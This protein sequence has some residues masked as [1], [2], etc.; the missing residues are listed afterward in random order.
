MSKN[1]ARKPLT[2]PQ[3]TFRDQVLKLLKSDGYR[4]ETK[5]G[6]SRLLDVPQNERSQLRQDLRELADQGEIE[7]RRGGRYVLAYSQQNHPSSGQSDATGVLRV[8][9]KGSGF[10]VLEKSATV[11]K[12]IRLPEKVSIQV[13]PE[14]MANALPGDRVALALTARSMPRSWSSDPRGEHRV[15]DLKSSDDLAV[16]GRVI[17]VLDRAEHRVIGSLIVEKGGALALKPDS[18]T[19]PPRLEL[20]SKETLRNP[21]NGERVL[22]EITEWSD[23]QLPPQAGLLERVGMPGDDGLAMREIVLA[24]A[25][26]E[27]FPEAVLDEARAIPIRIPEDE[28]ARR[29]DWRDRLVFTIDPGDARDF[30]D[31]ISI[32]CMENEGWELAVHIADV[33]T[34]VKPGSAMD[35]EARGRG[36]STYLPHR[37]IPMLPEELSNGICSL[38]PHEDRLTR[39]VVMQFDRQGKRGKTR[40]VSAVIHSKARLTYEE[41]MEY[42]DGKPAAEGDP[43]PEK[44]REA[45]KLASLLRKKRFQHG[46][47]DMDFPEVRVKLDARGRPVDLVVSENDASHQLIEECMLATNE[48]VARELRQRGKPCVY[49]VHEDPAEER[50]LDFRELARAAGFRVGDLS[51]RAEA[52]KLLDAAKGHPAEQAIKIGFLKSLKRADYRTESDGHYGLAKRDYTHFTSPIRRYADLI[53]H[54]C[55]YHEKG[56]APMN[57]A[58]MAQAAAHI[59]KTER[60]SAQ[61]EQ[62]SQRLMQFEFFAGIAEREPE[63]N[64]E[65]TVMECAGIGLFVEIDVWQVRGLVHYRDL[66]GR[67]AYFDRSAMRYSGLPSGKTLGAGDRVVVSFKTVDL[68]GRKLDFRLVDMQGAGKERR[69][70]QRKPA[71]RKPT[72]RDRGARKSSP[73]GK[74]SGKKASGEGGAGGAPKG[75]DKKQAVKRGRRSQRRKS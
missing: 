63:R 54:R 53:V 72:R 19:Y 45:W 71:S 24:N 51:H 58:E 47:L 23:P 4:P 17:E 38:V 26:R 6:I 40:F 75:K 69:P 73:D 74:G 15:I 12:G 27:K 25:I 28:I 42:I 46:G 20:S 60:A 10:V 52:Q 41:A 57:A 22:V 9:Y 18:S 59:S 39:C 65:A 64:F 14:S 50:L 7:C 48:A 66:P 55:L 1:Q 35:K 13:S 34:Y 33:S 37:V 43:V 67:R 44:I 61:A 56:K 36:N 21:R 3:E 11:A 70:R 2:H 31:A 30:D 32:R 16:D 62:D 5:S 49:R 29:E 68:E 8:R